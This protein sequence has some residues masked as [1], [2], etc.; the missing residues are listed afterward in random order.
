M[1]SPFFPSPLSSLL[2]S[3][4]SSSPPDAGLGAISLLPPLPWQLFRKTIETEK[5]SIVGQDLAG[6]QGFTVPLSIPCHLHKCMRTHAR[7]THTQPQYISG[8]LVRLANGLQCAS[9][10]C[11]MPAPCSLTHFCCP[12]YDWYSGSCSYRPEQP[13]RMQHG[14]PPHRTRVSSAGGSATHI[15][16]YCVSITI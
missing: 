10:S 11:L 15:K 4:L 3:P 1:L 7:Q 8:A 13:R 9:K 16:W 5:L 14:F 6:W 12:H 2:S